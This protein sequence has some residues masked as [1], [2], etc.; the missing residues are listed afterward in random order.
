MGKGRSVPG[1]GGSTAG[2][3]DEPADDVTVEE[4]GGL[5]V[6]GPDGRGGGGIK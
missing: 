6:A 5:E 1:T 2:A 4:G 3:E